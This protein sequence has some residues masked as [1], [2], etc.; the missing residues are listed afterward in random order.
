MGV[1]GIQPFVNLSDAVGILGVLCFRQ[2]KR[3]LGRGG[4]DGLEGRPHTA[5][6]FLGDIA[7]AHARR[8]LDRS[9][10]GLI[11]PG[12][13]LQQCG[14]SRAIAPHQ[15]D[16]TLRRQGR[17]SPVENEMAAQAQRNAFKSQHGRRLVAFGWRQWPA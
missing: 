12:D 10:V 5:W 9:V 17:G 2:Q 15:T 3:A 4:K 7:D 13:E 1:D 11:E 14:F 16:A 8:S 6:R